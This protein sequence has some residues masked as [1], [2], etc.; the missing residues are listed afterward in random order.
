[1]QSSSRTNKKKKRITFPIYDKYKEGNAGDSITDQYMNTFVSFM[2]EEQSNILYVMALHHY[3]L[4]STSTRKK[5]CV[6]DG[7]KMPDGKG[8]RFDLKNLPI[9]LIRIIKNLIYDSRKK[10]TI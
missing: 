8:V 3:A 4:T 2:N 5:P 1:M 10:S 9:D 6:Y 7:N